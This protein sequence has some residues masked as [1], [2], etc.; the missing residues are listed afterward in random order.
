MFQSV[1]ARAASTNWRTILEA[2]WWIPAQPDGNHTIITLTL[3]V[4]LSG[5]KWFNKR[6]RQRSSKTIVLFLVKPVRFVRN[7]PSGQP[8]VAQWPSDKPDHP[9]LSCR[10]VVDKLAKWFHWLITGQ[11]FGYENLIQFDLVTDNYLIGGFVSL[12][13]PTRTW[14]AS[15]NSAHNLG[16][17]GHGRAY[18]LTL[19]F[20]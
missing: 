18:S 17:I 3:G 5:R 12:K 6:S 19:S 11:A 20:D 2:W 9:D 8:K 7:S 4:V 14:S 15:A 1:C 16:D 10:Q 13:L